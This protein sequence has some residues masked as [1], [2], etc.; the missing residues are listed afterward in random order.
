[1]N[2]KTQAKM[3]M[4]QFKTLLLLC[5]FTSCNKS[6]P[7]DVIPLDKMIPIIEDVHIA[8]AVLINNNVYAGKQEALSYYKY[9][10][11]KHQITQA[12]FEKS[13]E[14]YAQNPKKLRKSYSKILKRLETRDSL[15]KAEEEARTD[16]LQLWKGHL[17]YTI[18][19]Y[20]NETLP[21]S[22][23]VKYPKTYTI[24]AEIKIYKDSQVKEIR[25]YFAFVAPDTSYVLSTQTLTVDT[26][27][28][29]FEI[30]Q[31]VEDSTVV[32]LEGDFFPTQNDSIEQFKHYEIRKIQI[33]TTNINFKNTIDSLPKR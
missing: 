26:V 7:D 33:T 2:P 23:L 25:P 15:L 9:I 20:T 24:S 31:M 28:Q 13:M 4:K 6:I 1:M 27:F 30:S 32:R 14:Y 5:L 3:P 17:A 11:K 10:Y 16:T 22:I 18:E 21:V 29:K 12:K 8:D 19:K